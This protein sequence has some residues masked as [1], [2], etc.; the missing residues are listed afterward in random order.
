MLP[1]TN[2]KLLIIVGPTSSGKSELAVSLAKKFNGEIIS[3][4]SRQIYKGMDLGTGKIEGKWTTYKSNRPTKSYSS[5]IY[6][7]IRHHLIDFINPKKQYSASL[8]QQAAKK[9]INDITAR[10]KLPILCGGT[11]HWI[12]ALVY[13]QPLPNVKPN[14]KLRA[15][16]EK[17]SAEALFGRIRA[18]DP[19]RASTIDPHNKRRLIRAL[20]IIKSTGRPVPELST[21]HYS[22]PTF[23]TLWLGIHLP[24]QT[25]YKKIDLRLHSRLKAGM[26]K[27][28]KKLHA[29]GLSWKKLESFGLEYKFISLFLQKKIT[30]NAMLT[31]LSFAIK[32]YSKRQL[33]WW[34]RNKK[35]IWLK[36]VKKAEKLVTNFLK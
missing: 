1:A 14:K 33:T 4:D 10:G 17:L 24:P 34:K 13:D 15:Q 18:Q 27:E 7:T 36:D 32:H 11:A 3:C 28:V 25:L 19:V 9:A 23:P 16:L 35:I 21:I 2:Y 22:L 29:S 12:D 20:E 26:V 6:K 30:R 8:F 5:Y 31:Q